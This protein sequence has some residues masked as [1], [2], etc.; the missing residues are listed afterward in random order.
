MAAPTR[1][2]LGGRLDAAAGAAAEKRRDDE[3]VAVRAGRSLEDWPLQRVAARSKFMVMVFVVN[4]AFGGVGVRRD[5]REN[6]SLRNTEI[7]PPNS[8][9]T[10]TLDLR[11]ATTVPAAST[12]QLLEHAEESS[13]RCPTIHLLW[14]SQSLLF[15]TKR[16]YKSTYYKHKP[17]EDEC[18]P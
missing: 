8:S 14:C 16:R 5:G 1:G 17:N 18:N 4:F 9:A 3:E 7:F 12:Y 11:Y 10:S 2:M 13:T 6:S 15:A